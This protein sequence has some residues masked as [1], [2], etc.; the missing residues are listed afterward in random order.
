[1]SGDV[2]DFNNIEKR[3]VIK[4]PPLQGKAPKKFTPFW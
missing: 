2:R 1:M 4:Y 3:A